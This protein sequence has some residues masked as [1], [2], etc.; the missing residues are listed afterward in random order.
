[1]DWLEGKMGFFDSGFGGDRDGLMQRNRKKEKER[2]K[3]EERME[4]WKKYEN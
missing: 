4:K 3:K 1:M 2:K